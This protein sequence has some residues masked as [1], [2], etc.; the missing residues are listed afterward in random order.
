MKKKIAIIGAGIA[1]LTLANLIQKNSNFDFML[2]EKEDKLSLAEGFG[3]QL[4]PNSISILN[5]I[6]F[7]KI[8][9]EN[10]A[11][12]KKLNF[13]TIENDKICDLNLSQFNTE[14]AKYTTLRRSIL[15]KFLKD[16][17]YTHQI[18][19]GKKINKISEVNEKLSINF[20]DNTNDLVDYMVAADGI[21]TNTRSFLEASKNKP[22]F[23][24]AIAIRTILQSKSGLNIDENEINLFMASNAHFVIYPINKK[25]ELN[26]VCTLREKNFNP[27]NMRL[28]L[29]KKLFSQ[30]ENLKDLFKEDCR[31]WPLYASQKINISSNKKVFYLGDAFYA[32]LPTLAQGASQSIEG[33]FELFNLLKEN[34][35]DVHGLYYKRRSERVKIIKKRSDFNFFAFHINSLIF[36]FIRKVILKS[37]VKNKKFISNYLGEVYKN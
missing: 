12:P 25:N 5:Q 27:T 1:G 11:Q 31:S 9:P 8:Q 17:I 33:A 28:I 36:K 3:I 10:I 7:K 22:K 14:E 6:G 19:F 32:F 30:N 29:S 16:E 24:N 20:N 15:I 2:Y 26:L 37:L 21:F 23:K 4:A 35:K 13:Y 34:N 18:C